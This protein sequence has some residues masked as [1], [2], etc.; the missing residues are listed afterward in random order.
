M[1][2]HHLSLEHLVRPPKHT[3][4]KAPALFLFHGYGSNEEDLFSFAPELPESLCVVSVRAPHTLPPYGYAWYSIDFD[5]DFGKWSNTEEAKESVLKMKTFIEEAIV[6]YHL[7]P[8]K[9][10][11]LGFS[12]GTVLSFALALSYPEMVQN[13]LGLSGHI[14]EKTLRPGYETKDHSHLKAYVSHGEYDQVIPF[15]WAEKTP[16]FLDRLGIEYIFE[17]F[18]TGH[19]VSREN[20]YGMRNWLEKHL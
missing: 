18:P 13:I 11:L 19:G 12:Q 16:A 8:E 1:T 17:H 10:S 5:A 9:I 15:S 6:A 3:T 14:D 2:P 4:D 7:D 20:F